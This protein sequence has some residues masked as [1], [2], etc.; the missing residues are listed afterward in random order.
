[1]TVY[2]GFKGRIEEFEPILKFQY[3]GHTGI[4]HDMSDVNIPALYHK[5][6]CVYSEISWRFGYPVFMQRANANGQFSDYI[7]GINRLITALNKPVYL[8]GSVTDMKKMKAD[9][10]IPITFKTSTMPHGWGYCGIWNANELNVKSH[11]E[12]LGHVKKTYKT[13]LD[14]SCGYL[15]IADILLPEVKFILGDINPV[16]IGASYHKLKEYYGKD[17]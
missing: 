17:K 16:C 4:L 9:H 15:S 5:A 6:D 11:I 3:M 2:H 1:M 14:F 13:V 8:V 12:V 7:D 10:I